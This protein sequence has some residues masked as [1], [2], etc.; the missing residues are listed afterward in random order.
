MSWIAALAL[1]L[2]ASLLAGCQSKDRPPA[3]AAESKPAAQAPPAATPPAP[4]PP[5]EPAGPEIPAAEALHRITALADQICACKDR[6][7]AEA[8]NAAFQNENRQLARRIRTRPTQAEADAM[9]AQAKRFSGCVQR[10]P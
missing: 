2:A 6:A 7:C 1:A 9:Q 10:L 3:P 8:A 4:A 5:A